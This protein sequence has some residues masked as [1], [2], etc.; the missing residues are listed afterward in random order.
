VVLEPLV[1]LLHELPHGRRLM[2]GFTLRLWALVY[3]LLVWGAIIY[4]ASTW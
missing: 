1:R 3:L 2:S 4:W